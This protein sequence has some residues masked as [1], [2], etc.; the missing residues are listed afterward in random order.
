MKSAT[1]LKLRLHIKQTCSEI[2][3]QS[4]ILSNVSVKIL[5]LDLFFYCII[6]GIKIAL[7]QV[8]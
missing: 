8:Q 6:I 3:Q 5:D 4:S 1:D 2:E 7:V